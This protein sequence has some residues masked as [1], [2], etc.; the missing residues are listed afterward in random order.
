MDKIKVT[1]EQFENPCKGCKRPEHC[2]TYI[3]LTGNQIEY[4]DSDTI[5]V[6]LVAWLLTRPDVYV[7]AEEDSLNTEFWNVIIPLTCRYYLNDRCS[8]YT[9]RPEVCDTY[10]PFPVLNAP[11]DVISPCERY[12]NHP[13]LHRF[14]NLFSF[15]EYI[16]NK[17]GLECIEHKD[18]PID[19]DKVEIID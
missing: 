5:D 16:K 13:S 11:E 7:E 3:I 9:D 4:E 14:T 12:E 8:I 6:D 15:R 19:M 18:Y 2:C 1:R 10:K 17:F